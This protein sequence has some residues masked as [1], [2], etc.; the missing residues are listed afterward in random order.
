MHLGGFEKTRA[1]RRGRKDPQIYLG[2]LLIRARLLHLADGKRHLKQT[3]NICASVAATQHSH[4]NPQQQQ[5]HNGRRNDDKNRGSCVVVVAPVFCPAVSDCC[6]LYRGGLVVV[7]GRRHLQA[8]ATCSGRGRPEARL[9]TGQVQ[10]DR[11]GLRG[12]MKLTGPQS[13]AMSPFLVSL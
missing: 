4:S 5:P 2:I 13:Y 6:A 10:T 7:N 8:P 11:P 12:F 9:N 1:E 3:N